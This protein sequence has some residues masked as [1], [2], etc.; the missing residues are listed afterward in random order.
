MLAQYGY[1]CLWMLSTI[2][3]CEWLHCIHS[4]INSNWTSY[5][6]FNCLT[7]TWNSF[8]PTQLNITFFGWMLA[9]AESRPQPTYRLETHA[10][11]NK[12]AYRSDNR[13]EWQQKS[14]T[15]DLTENYGSE[16][17]QYQPLLAILHI[18]TQEVW[19]NVWGQKALR[20]HKKQR[21]WILWA[22]PLQKQLSGLWV[23]ILIT[24]DDPQC[25]GF[26]QNRSNCC[27]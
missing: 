20:L 6:I 1:S 9:K 4:F 2:V 19:Q 18:K 23:S 22:L 10:T 12:Q 15:D 8:P 11:G 7:A 27:M 21:P 5:V 3:H 25:E 14:Y 13:Q 24:G 26:M 17:R 16:C